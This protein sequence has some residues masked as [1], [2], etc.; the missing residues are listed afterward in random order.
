MGQ[1]NHFPGDLDSNGQR[2]GA[3][4]C[5]EETG[6]NTLDNLGRILEEKEKMRG[7]RGGEMGTGAWIG[8]AEVRPYEGAAAAAAGAGAGAIV[9]SS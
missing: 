1:P 4:A 7:L 6:H 9:M 5:R 2:P 8:G 3:C